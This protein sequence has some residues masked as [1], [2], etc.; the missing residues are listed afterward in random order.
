M[1][2]LGRLVAD[3]EEQQKQGGRREGLGGGDGLKLLLVAS[4]RETR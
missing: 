2:G 1:R 4:V 3:A